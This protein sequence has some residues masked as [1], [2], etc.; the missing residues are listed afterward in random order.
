MGTCRGKTYFYSCLLFSIIML[1]PENFSR[2]KVSK[3]NFCET[4]ANSCTTV[5][6]SITIN[7]NYKSKQLKLSLNEALVGKD[8]KRFSRNAVILKFS[9]MSKPQ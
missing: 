8:A 5:W 2:Y 3:M 7:T 1:K 6:S 9:E 4:K